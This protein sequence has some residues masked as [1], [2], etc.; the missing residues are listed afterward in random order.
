MGFLLLVSIKAVLDLEGKGG[1]LVSTLGVAFAKGNEWGVI[2][3]AD[4]F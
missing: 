1:D 4:S 3:L 2:D